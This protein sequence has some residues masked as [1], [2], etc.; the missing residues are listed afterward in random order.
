MKP[1]GPRWSSAMTA[2]SCS[3]KEKGTGWGELLATPQ[4]VLGGRAGGR[5]GDCRRG[6]CDWRAVC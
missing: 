6:R 4:P 5:G 1:A 2:R 3:L